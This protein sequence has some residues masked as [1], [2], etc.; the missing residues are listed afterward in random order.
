MSK[1]CIRNVGKVKPKPFPSAV[2]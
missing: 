2:R 1:S